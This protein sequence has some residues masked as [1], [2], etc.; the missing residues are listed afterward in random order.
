MAAVVDRNIRSLLERREA[1][2][3]ARGR[4]DKLADAVTGFT[5][6]MRFVA[7]HLVLFGGW[8]LWNSGWLPVPRFDPSFVVL[9]MVASVEAIFLSTFVLIS[10]NRM[11]ALADE[12]AELNLQISLLSEHEV[13]R[14]V[15]IVAGIAR[16]LGLPE[17]DDPELEELQQDIRPERVIEAMQA[18]R[19]SPTRVHRDIVA[20]DERTETR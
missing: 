7:I 11:N 2:A 3:L 6:S 18:H 13:T 14:I 19:D 16:S 10:Q 17:A 4:Q 9:A 20:Q 5:G 1:E 15:T 8:I 12:R